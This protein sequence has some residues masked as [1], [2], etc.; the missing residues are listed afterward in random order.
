MSDTDTS[1]EPKQET[2]NVVA[3]RGTFQPGAAKTATTEPAAPAVNEDL[4]RVLA[5][6]TESAKAGEIVG[7]G[8]IS[9]DGK[10]GFGTGWEDASDTIATMHMAVGVLQ[11]RLTD[12]V[13]G[14]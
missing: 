5:M 4:L 2:N 10:G 1:V 9:V 11:R 6:L 8:F 3:L 12:F 14:E 13:I 7:L